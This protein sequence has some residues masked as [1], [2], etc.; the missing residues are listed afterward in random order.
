MHSDPG[1][2][3]LNLTGF[4]HPEIDTIA[5]QLQVEADPAAAADLIGQLQVLIAEQVPFIMLAYPDG[6][7]V[8][9]SE[10]YSDWEFIAGQGI[11]SKLSLLPVSARP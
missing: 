10:V 6:A 5:S 4:A 3:F 11:V 1:I 8:Y 2:G 9:N 7:Y